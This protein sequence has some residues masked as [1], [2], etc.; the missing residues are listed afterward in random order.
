MTIARPATSLGSTVRPPAAPPSAARMRAR[1]RQR[2]RHGVNRSVAGAITASSGIGAGVNQPRQCRQRQPDGT[3][4]LPPPASPS[5][6]AA[7]G[8]APAARPQHRP[9]GRPCSV[10]LVTTGGANGAG[11]SITARQARPAQPDRRP[12]QLSGAA[13]PARPAAPAA[14][15]Q[16]RQVRPRLSGNGSAGATALSNQPTAPAPIAITSTEGVSTGAIEAAAARPDASAGGA[17][18]ARSRS[19]TALP[20]MSS[21]PR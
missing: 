17:T 21:P 1:T 8:T 19:P 11:G 12:G 9:P 16:R 4:T 14:R 7:A 15:G 3:G 20:A 18:P 10:S 6:G 5:T 13:K 2:R